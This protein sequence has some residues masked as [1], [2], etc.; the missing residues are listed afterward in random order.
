MWLFL[1]TE[2]LL[3]GGLFCAY[4]IFRRNHPEVFMYAHQFLDTTWG[5]I[6]TVVLLVSSFTM[7][8]AVTAS[9]R[10]QRHLTSILLALT[11]LGGVG[12]MV[13][14]AVEYSHKFHDGLMW[15]VHYDPAKH[16]HGHGHNGAHGAAATAAHGAADHAAPADHGTAGAAATAAP[17]AST[18]PEATTSVHAPETSGQPA[19]TGAEAADLPPERAPL[20][21]SQV[22]L[23]PAGP[24][25]L[26]TGGHDLH[27]PRPDNV[28]W[29]F[30]VYFTMTG[31][32]G[33]HVLAGMAVIGWLF[34]RSVRGDFSADYF[35]PV[36]LGGLYWHLVDLIWIFLFPLLYLIH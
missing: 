23:A 11:F 16:E 5:A 4:A 31:L 25:G 26:H 18:H 35:T 12:F 14:K 13:I 28:H 33:L 10:G 30:G 22:A 34:V 8:W 24:A 6:N 29:F 20:E 9:Q 7:A 1:A 2:V 27:G 32:H 36:D 21:P 3:F 15:G 17:A 19:A